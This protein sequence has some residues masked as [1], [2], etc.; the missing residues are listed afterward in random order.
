MKKL[1]LICFFIFFS[2]LNASG[3]SYPIK[4]IRK[5]FPFLKQKMNNH[6]IVY[7]D[8][9]ATSQKPKPIIDKLHHFYLEEYATVHRSV[10][11]KSIL[12]TRK[13]NQARVSI[14]QFINASSS[15]EIIFTRGTTDS[16]N[17]VAIS[18][19]NWIIKPGDEIIISQMEHHSNMVPWQIICQQKKAKLKIIPMKSSGELDLEVF[20]KIISPKTK[21]VAIGHV[22]NS[23]G[24]VNPIQEIAKI[25]HQNNALVIVDGAQAITHVPVD[26]QK[27]DV[28]FYAFSGH[29]MYAPN[30]IGILY[31]KQELLEKM[32]PVQGGGDMIRV[33]SLNKATFQKPPIKFEAGTPII[34]EAVAL[35]ETIQYLNSIGIENI[36]NWEHDLLTYATSKI[37]KIKEV[38]IIGNAPNKSSIIS[39]I[40]QDVSPKDVGS[41]M[42]QK[43][44][45]IRTGCHCAQP[46]M[47]KLHIKG[48]CRISFGI[49][50]TKEEIDYFIAC[51]NELIESKKLPQ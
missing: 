47:R 43:G 15:S 26:V 33:V 12:A 28:D 22:A 7:L 9:A 31:G 32:P 45:A 23:T 42:N 8:T 6:P 38:Q 24:T 49:Y 5:D 30:G 34:A 10:Y 27:L 48:T 25:A 35:G 16:L 18:L 41:F 2:T 3:N 17:L 13:Y 11:E 39:F 19:G 50:N 29:K 36:F 44:I 40:V 51:L 46:V 20:K 4:K 21:I 37:Q 1:Y 14:Q